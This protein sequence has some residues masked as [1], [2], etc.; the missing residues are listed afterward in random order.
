MQKTDFKPFQRI[1][2]LEEIEYKYSNPT[3]TITGKY[4]PINSTGTIIGIDNSYGVDL[5][6]E[7][8]EPIVC[9]H[10]FT[11]IKNWK[12]FLKRPCKPNCGI[13]ILDK[14][15]D[16]F[17][18]QIIDENYSKYR[19][20]TLDKIRIEK[21]HELIPKGSVGVILYIDPDGSMAVEWE[22]ISDGHEFLKNKD[23]IRRCKK[24]HGRWIN[25]ESDPK[26][27]KFVKIFSKAE[28]PLILS[29]RRRFFFD[30][31]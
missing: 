20:K 12:S 24:N 17:N 7:M 10:D 28:V 21:D 5:L 31:E 3:G 27:L 8:D 13:W 2:F 30:E 1:K 4:I 25:T 19:F 9:G 11:A 29:K 6:V 16:I 14:E 23:L 26:I 22:N 18:I 15:L